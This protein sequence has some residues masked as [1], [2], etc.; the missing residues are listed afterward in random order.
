[1]NEFIFVIHALF[2]SI[3]ILVSMRYGKQTLISMVALMAVLA[4]LF[5]NKQITLLGFNATASDVYIIGATLGITCLQEFY[6]RKTSRKAILISFGMMILYAIM[7]QLH[8]LYIPSCF[9]TAQQHFCAILYSAPR[10]MGASLLSYSISEWFNYY[11]FA[12][13]TQLFPRISFSLRAFTTTALTQLVDTIIFTV[14]GLYG[15]LGSLLN[16]I[17]VAYSIKLITIALIIPF[18]SLA[19]YIYKPQSEKI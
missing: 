3:A 7:S 9:D 14:V 17:T 13:I 11:L 19:K 1:M 8:L 4:N 5:V 15:L 12:K 2:I 6:G 16:I 18:L 10:L